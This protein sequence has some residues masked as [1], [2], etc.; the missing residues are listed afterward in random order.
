MAITGAPLFAQWQMGACAHRAQ[1]VKPVNRL[2][3]RSIAALLPLAERHGDYV[4]PEV[5]NTRLP[6]RVLMVMASSEERNACRRKL[7]RDDN[8]D[9][10]L[11]ETEHGLEGLSIADNQPLHCI[12]LDQQL[13]D[14][15]GLEFL[16]ELRAHA[17]SHVP[18]LWM[19]S[20][21]GGAMVSDFQQNVCECLVKD[22]KGNYL[23]LMPVMLKHVLEGYQAVVSRHRA[24]TTYRNLVEQLPAITYM[25]SLEPGNSMV[26]VSPQISR[27]GFAAEL[28]LSQTGFKLQQVCEDDRERVEREFR[29]CCQTGERFN[30]EYRMYGADGRMFWFHDVANVVLDEKSRP[31]V[32]QGV[33]MDITSARNAEMELMHQR[34]FLERLVSER[35]ARLV[36]R[37]AM[38]ESC[39]ASLCNALE[40][41]SGGLKPQLMGLQSLSAGMG[42]HHV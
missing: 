41:L 10:E 8:Y 17:N 20:E 3:R 37:I 39:N 34:R 11:F 27:L 32:V 28:W 5:G 21:R 42:G 26:Y 24:E 25:V 38:L 12:I 13:S 19:A 16:A 35:T 23:E 15:S 29:V 33:M 40:R 4:M 14:M 1:S 6:V 9:V 7:L 18:V 36:R 2:Y 30:C 22:R 31:M